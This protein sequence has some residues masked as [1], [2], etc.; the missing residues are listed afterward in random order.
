MIF[1]SFVSFRALLRRGTI[2]TSKNDK[3]N[4]IKIRPT[5][6]LFGLGWVSGKSASVN[7]EVGMACRSGVGTDVND[8]EG[9]EMVAKVED[10]DPVV[11][12]KRLKLQRLV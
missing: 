8:T 7:V 5:I 1:Y 4:R 6:F 12:S 9:V 10:A 3:I 11:S 2:K